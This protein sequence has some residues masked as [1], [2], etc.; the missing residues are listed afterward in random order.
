[1]NN[2]ILLK[3][4][5][6]FHEKL[7]EVEF[8]Y[9]FGSHARL[10]ASPLS[11]IDIAVY[12]NTCRV[13]LDKELELYAILSRE[14]NSNSIDLI[15]LNNSDNTTLLA[16]IIRGGKVVYDRSLSLREDFELRILH[17]SIDFIYQRKV[18]AGK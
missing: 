3:L 11:D 10:D 18:F 7:K 15:I 2:R 6:I 9:L 1:M 8:A 13:S 5:E 17:D 16:E 14:L 12:L 4:A